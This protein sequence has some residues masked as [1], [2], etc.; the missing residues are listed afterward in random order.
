MDALNNLKILSL[1]KWVILF[2]GFLIFSLPLFSLYMFYLGI[3]NSTAEE[4]TSASI[5]LMGSVFP[6]LLVSIVLFFSNSGIKSLRN[7]TDAILSKYIPNSLSFV[8]DNLQS[9][10][11]FSQETADI[12]SNHVKGIFYSDYKISF[13]DDD[14]CTSDIKRNVEIIIRIEINVKRVNF[15]LHIPKHKI[16]AFAKLHRLCMDDKEGILKKMFPHCVS[17]QE[18]PLGDDIITYHYNPSF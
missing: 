18:A 3:E 16:E 8:P 9:I 5:A 14:V 17:T 10:T 2:L 12:A 6:V 7:K 13:V 4:I 15:N 1:P 11:D